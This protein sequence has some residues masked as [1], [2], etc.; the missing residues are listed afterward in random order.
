M[1]RAGRLRRRDA[2]RAS[3][4][5]RSARAVA[6]VCRARFHVQR[7]SCEQP[8]GD[9]ERREHR[10]QRTPLRPR[11]ARARTTAA[12][13]RATTAR[14]QHRQRQVLHVGAAGDA[15]DRRSGEAFE[16]DPLARRDRAAI[17]TTPIGFATDAADAHRLRRAAR[18][19]ASARPRMRPIQFG[20]PRERST[21]SSRPAATVSGTE[22]SLR[23][24]VVGAPQQPH[25]GVVGNVDRVPRDRAIVVRRENRF[26]G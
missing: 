6:R 10:G 21:G 16:R 7:A 2:A 23:R 3:R 11:Y 15:V 14:E 22:L 12:A 17:S 19:S 5:P 18:G 4:G 1:R 8:R 20:S 24:R 26:R 9:E 25:V 13:A